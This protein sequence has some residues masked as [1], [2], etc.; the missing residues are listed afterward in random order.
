MQATC[1]LNLP[2]FTLKIRE[3]G[4]KTEI[5]DMFRRRY[6][7]LT[8]EEW[9]RQHFLLYLH[10]HLA[11]PQSLIAVEKS[12]QVN[13]MIRRFDIAVFNRCGKALMLIECKAPEI[14]LKQSVLDQAG[15]YN[16]SLNVPYLVVT[17]GMKHLCYKIDRENNSWERLEEIPQYAEL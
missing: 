6:V 2:S 14:K 1:P 5:Y 11:Y 10:L 3:K 17:N 13:R 15:R 4:G 7:N 16:L 9:V 8:P 12:I